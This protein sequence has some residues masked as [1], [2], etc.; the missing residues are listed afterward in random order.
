MNLVHRSVLCLVVLLGCGWVAGCS[1][2]GP[3]SVSGKVTLDGQDVA[4]GAIDFMPADGKSPT[5]S[6]IIKNGRYEATVPVGSYRV[7]I[8]SPKVVGKKPRY[9]TPDSPMD[10]IIEERIPKK[11]NSESKLVREID[12][13]TTEVDFEL[14]TKE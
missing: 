14:K 10:D 5:A 3:R 2:S 12:G 11:F 6:G 13:K 4:E 8:K 1:G 9:K 7:V